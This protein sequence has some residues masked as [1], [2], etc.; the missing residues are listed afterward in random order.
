MTTLTAGEWEVGIDIKP[1][2]YVIT[3][4][5]GSGNISTNDGDINEILGKNKSGQHGETTS[6]TSELKSGQI[7]STN[8][9]QIKLTEK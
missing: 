4:L 7:L 2:R 5:Q 6:I 9:Q 3:S 1:G 8:L